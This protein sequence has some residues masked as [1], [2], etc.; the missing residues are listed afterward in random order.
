MVYGITDINTFILGT[1]FV[2]LLPGPNSLYVI[3]V[4]SQRG[5]GPGY[6]GACGIFAGDAI[7]MLLAA[8][9]AASLLYAAP[10]VFMLLQFAGAAYLA[11]LG[12][13]LI[14]SGLADWTT[15]D[16]S[17]R[18]TETT[19]LKDLQRPFRTALIISL[20]NPKAIM[21]F[22]SFFIQF[23][24]PGYPYPALSFL[25]LGTIVQISS[26][27][28]LSILIFGGVQLAQTFRRLPILAGL[29][30]AAVG[31]LFIG[32]GLRLAIGSISAAG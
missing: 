26:A 3:T 17:A 18:D 11:W 2:V 29:S 15:R 1:I 28:Y 9:G 31:V 7:L 24:E 23:V 21:F 10:T 16:S 27:L 30:K 13:G 4:A 8:T 5:I 12:I 6:L 14:R 32:F 20:L 19:T 22:I 25:I